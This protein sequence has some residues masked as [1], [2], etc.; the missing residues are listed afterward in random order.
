MGMREP[1]PTSPKWPASGLSTPSHG[2]RSRIP[3]T[4]DANHENPQLT[5]GYSWFPLRHAKATLRSSLQTVR[6]APIAAPSTGT[7]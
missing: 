6:A 2:Q 5:C 3:R 1:E 7:H 4:E